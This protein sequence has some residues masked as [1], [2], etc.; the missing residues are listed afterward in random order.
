MVIDEVAYHRM[1]KSLVDGHGL[2]IWNGYEEFRSPELSALYMDPANGHLVAQYP[3]GFAFVAAPFYALFGYHGLF[4]VNAL[5]EVG[6]V[7][8]CYRVAM[9]V[10]DDE[11]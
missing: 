2:Y 7:A 10:L 8:L 1:V 6:V 3:Y 5:A 4:L 9:Q 11:R